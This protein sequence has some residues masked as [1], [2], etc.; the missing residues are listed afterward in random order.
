MVLDAYLQ[1]YSSQWED[2][3]TETN[4]S[5]EQLRSLQVHDYPESLLKSISRMVEKDTSVVLVELLNLENPYIVAKAASD[6]SLRIAIQKQ[7]LYIFI[8]HAYRKEQTKFLTDVLIALGIFEAELGFIGKFN[9]FGQLIYEAFLSSL[10]KSEEYKQI[11][12]NLENYRVK[13]HDKSGS[14]LYCPSKL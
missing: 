8:P 4:Y 9:I 13:A 1:Y 7:A 12:N 6:Y 2:L 10:P 11:E 3:L 5:K 14:L